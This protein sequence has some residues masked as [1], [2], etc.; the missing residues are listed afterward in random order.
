MAAAPLRRAADVFGP[1][2]SAPLMSMPSLPEGIPRRIWRSG[3]RSPKKF[4]VKWRCLMTECRQARSRVE[5]PLPGQNLAVRGP[6][7]THGP[8]TMHA[9]G[10]RRNE[11]RA[12]GRSWA[13]RATRALAALLLLAVTSGAPTEAANDAFRINELAD[14]QERSSWTPDGRCVCLGSVLYLYLRSGWRAAPH[15][16][17]ST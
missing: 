2:G 14:G 4:T 1:A 9:Q 7:S 15:T 11:A 17:S 8:G 3:F 6:S 13:L 12:M 10:A 16:P 5:Y